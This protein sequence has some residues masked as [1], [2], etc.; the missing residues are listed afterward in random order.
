[1]ARLVGGFCV[2]HDPLILGNADAPPREQAARVMQAFAQVRARIAT[3]RADTAIVIGDDHCTMFGPGCVPAILIGTGDLE[4]PIEPWLGIPRRAVNNHPPLA[5][6]LV[7]AGFEAGFDWTVSRSLALDHST[8]VPI[9]LALPVGTRV[10]PVY[11][12]SGGDPLIPGRRC[13]ELG[14]MLGAAIA[15]WPGDERVVMIGT[16]GISHWVGMSDMG[17]VNEAFDRRILGMVEA[18]DLDGLARLSAEE[19][20]ATAGNGALE[21]RNWIVAMA[22]MPPYNARVLAYEPVPEWI[23]GLGFAELEVAP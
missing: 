8:M 10:I 19:I 9:H 6:H 2:P 11:I 12:N 22:A 4:G 15:S 1:M 13:L 7:E 17:R 5:Q 3:L 14:R 21:V 20:V 18:R 23:T 16:G